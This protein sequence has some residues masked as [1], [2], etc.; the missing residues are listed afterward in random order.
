MPISK[1]REMGKK[2][3]WKMKLILYITLYWILLPPV[4]FSREITI[5]TDFAF[6]A[7][8]PESVQVEVGD[9]ITWINSDGILHEIYFP[10]SPSNSDEKRLRY[11]LSNKHSV[12]TTVTK[13]GEYDYYCRYHG[14]HGHIRVVKPP[15]G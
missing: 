8:S 14:M 1:R 4:A 13:P 5:V 3:R 10:I 9:R 6:L 12:S 11:L 7:F 15:S 2:N